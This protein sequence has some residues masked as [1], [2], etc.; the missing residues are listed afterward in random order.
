MKDDLIFETT[1]WKVILMDDQTYLGRCVIVLKRKCGDLAEVTEEEMLDFL[2]LVKILE[3]KARRAFGAVMFNWGCLMNDA[4]QN[5][6]PDPQV[7]WHFRPRYDREVT[8]AGEKF[9]DTDFGHHYLRGTSR[10]L[11]DAVR[12][13]I[14]KALQS[15]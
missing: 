5:T 14:I 12:Q 3:S 6:P 8:F 2:N 9:V 1:H 15:S 7:H 13:E 4:Y 11:S 10:I